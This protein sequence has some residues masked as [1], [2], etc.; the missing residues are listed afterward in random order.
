M[1]KFHN[2]VL[3]NCRGEDIQFDLDR[4][5]VWE[6]ASQKKWHLNWVLKALGMMLSKQRSQH[7]H[8][9]VRS[10]EL[11]VPRRAPL[12]GPN[13]T[14]CLPGARA[15][16][17][18]RLRRC[19]PSIVSAFCFLLPFLRGMLTWE[20]RFDQ[21]CELKFAGSVCGWG[22]PCAFFFCFLVSGGYCFYFFLWSKIDLPSDLILWYIT[23]WSP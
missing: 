7:K 13:R 5:E 1:C 15:W 20:L 21:A 18:P 17:Q 22:Y 4:L 9:G 23:E 14:W 6:Q 12:G 19:L 3:K 11:F 2:R 8:R 16:G 10:S